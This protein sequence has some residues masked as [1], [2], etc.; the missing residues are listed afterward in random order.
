[1]AAV[2]K[3]SRRDKLRCQTLVK[4][5]A[6]K[7]GGWQALADEL[8]MEGDSSRATAQ[9]WHRRGR[10]SIAYAAQVRDLA[11]KHEIECALSDLSPQAKHVEKL[12]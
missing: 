10:I 1:M 2:V 7:L 11:R 4:Q 6:D 9:S 5:L 8:G 12:T 3:W